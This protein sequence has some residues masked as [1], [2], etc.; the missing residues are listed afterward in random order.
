MTNSK[1]SGLKIRL[2][3]VRAKLALLG[4]AVGE[5]RG[6]MAG[7]M[8]AQSAI[9]KPIQSRG[10]SRPRKASKP[11]WLA[12]LR[13][14]MQTEQGVRA[15]IVAAGYACTLETMAR[16][17]LNFADSQSLIARFVTDVEVFLLAHEL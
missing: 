11:R 5:Q 12:G 16:P 2:A 4:E 8:H 14:A 17:E 6:I 3:G 15:E 10:I 1:K 7:L 13:D 9:V